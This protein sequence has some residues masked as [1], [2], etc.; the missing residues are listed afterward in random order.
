MSGAAADKAELIKWWDALEAVRLSLGDPGLDRQKALQLARECRHADAQW[1]AALFPAGTDVTR[2]E[3]IRVLYAG[4][5]GR[6]AG[7]ARALDECVER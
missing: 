4:T 1:L 5:G 6:P 3:M 7:C 2:D